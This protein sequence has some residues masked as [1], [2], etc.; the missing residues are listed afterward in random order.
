LKKALSKV[1]ATLVMPR[2]DIGIA[3]TAG[4][5]FFA[6]VGQGATEKEE[7]IKIVISPHL[8]QA[9]R[10]SG[11]SEEVKN[12]IET[13]YPQPFPY[14]VYAWEKKLFNRGIV[15]T[16]K[17]LDAIKSETSIQPFTAKEDP[18]RQ[19]KLFAYNDSI[20]QKKIIIRHIN[21]MVMLKG[22]SEPCR[23]YEIATNGSLLD[24]HH[25]SI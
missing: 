11:S 20:L 13:H 9:A 17:V 5:L 4:E 24:K 2:V 25:G 12:Y 19:E 18:F 16:E 21:E 7:K 8:S 10:L 14:Y 15:I 22:I 1:A 23:I 6:L 3:I